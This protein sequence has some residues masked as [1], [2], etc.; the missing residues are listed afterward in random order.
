[1]K[2]S[3]IQALFQKYFG[4]EPSFDSDAANELALGIAN[5]WTI[6]DKLMEPYVSLGQGKQR[7]TPKD[8]R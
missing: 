5:V 4:N 3:E 2:A 7:A 1:M 6:I 8:S